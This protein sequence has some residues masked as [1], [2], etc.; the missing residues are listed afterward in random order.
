MQDRGIILN[1]STVHA[2]R[3]SKKVTLICRVIILNLKLPR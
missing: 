3:I 2:H 1:V